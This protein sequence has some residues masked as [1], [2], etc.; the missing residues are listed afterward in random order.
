MQTSMSFDRAGDADR[1]RSAIAGAGQQLLQ[2]GSLQGVQGPMRCSFSPQRGEKV[3][4]ADE[5]CFSLQIARV[6][7]TSLLAL[8]RHTDTALNTA[9]PVGPPPAQRT[10]IPPAAGGMTKIPSR[11]LEGWVVAV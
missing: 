10:A 4:Q 3:P 9:T 2:A 6:R 11:L 7:T 1:R 5:G 8:Y